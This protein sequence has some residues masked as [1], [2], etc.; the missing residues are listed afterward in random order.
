MKRLA[1]VVQRYGDEINGGAE[2]HAR[3]LA[4]KLTQLFRVEILTSCARNYTDW[5]MEFAPGECTLDGISVR[6]FSHPE[7]NDIGRARV[8]LVHK[9]RFKL[10]HL[11]SRLP[12]ARVL[13]PRG[14]PQFDGLDFLR[15][16]GPHCQGLLEY[17]DAAGNRYD[18]VIFFT[19]LYEPSALGIQHWGRRSIL[20][21]LLH[22]EKP[23][24][25][26]VF[27][28]V[29]RSAGAIL[30]NTAAE[31]DLAA[32]LYGLDTRDA[33]VA[34]LGIEVK[35]PTA[36]D[37]DRVLA[38]YGLQPGY[39]IYVGRIDVAKGC[40]ELICAFLEYAKRE[41]A[42]KLVLVGQRI[43]SVPDG[44]GIVCTGFISEDE[45]NALVA[46]AA[47]LV[48]PSH[49]ESLSMVLLEAMALQVP[50]IAN[51]RCEVLADHLRASGAGSTYRSRRQIIAAFEHML[52]LPAGERARLGKLGAAYVQSHYAWPRV[53]SVFTKA[54]AQV[55][56]LTPPAAGPPHG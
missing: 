38:R 12:G 27:H 4:Q 32:R 8:P 51:G 47:A 46:S 40:R 50:V 2:L 44:H 34:G 25:L 3:L 30:F 5:R 54:I 19:A 9:L 28:S 1:I 22:D 21:P 45:R 49:Y 36:S 6:R 55:T 18:A 37:R 17:L 53:L 15:H 11:L 41:P 26:P 56:A 39:L 48:I 43:M 20:V 24:Y 42:A 14:D 10:R 33:A 16:Q 13:R 7:R 52:K 29:L 23:M 31:R 35:A